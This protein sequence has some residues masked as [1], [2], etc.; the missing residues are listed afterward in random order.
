MLELLTFSVALHLPLS[1]FVEDIR[2]FFQR[3]KWDGNAF[4]AIM[5][6]YSAN[7]E[8]FYHRLT[9]VLPE[10]FELN[11]IFFLRFNHD[12]QKDQ[13]EIDRELHLSH[14]HQP[15]SNGLFEHYCRRWI[16]VAILEELQGDGTEKI[17]IGVQ[18]S[19]YIGTEDE[20]L[21][22]TIAR[23]SYP[24]PTKNV[25]VTLGLQITDEL[26]STVNFWN[27]TDVPFREVNKTCERCPL[28]DCTE[29]AAPPTVADR[30][31]QLKAIQQRLEELSE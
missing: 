16:A 17:K 31:Q 7:P 10:F 15:H 27:D 26:K 28:T 3:R 8:M 18:R 6:K 23:T 19:K 24:G 11:Q 20:Y 2:S 12:L 29:R 4:L 21:C 13:F 14:R 30:R 5:N 22:L 9:N 1:A 25:S